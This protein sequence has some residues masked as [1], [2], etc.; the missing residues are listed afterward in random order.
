VT[1]MPFSLEEYFRTTY[2]ERLLVKIPEREDDHLTPATK[3]LEKR[4]EMKE[5]EQALSAQKEE[6]QMK[7]ESLQ[8][9]QEELERKECTLKESLLKF[10]KFLK[11]NDSKR[12]RALKKALE[13]KASKQQKHQEHESLLEEINILEEERNKIQEKL[14]M[15]KK[16]HTYMDAVLENSDEFS[17]V[18]EITSR[19]ETLSSTYQD[20]LERDQSNQDLIENK[21]QFLAKFTEDRQNEIM[22]YNNDLSTMQGDLDKAKSRTVHLESNWNQIQTTAASKTL[23]LGRIRMATLNLF[24]LVNTQ[25]KI[26]GVTETDSDSQLEKISQFIQDLSQITA[27]IRK[28]EGLSQTNQTVSF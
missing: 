3:L 7:M 26:G 12:H 28:Q 18:R 9:R 11:E 27:E 21:R 13:E 14:D 15:H 5:V 19:Y 4:R 22:S 20:L 6:F 24:S 1:K 23:E 2:E 25:L 16:F 10:D 8:Q 17:E